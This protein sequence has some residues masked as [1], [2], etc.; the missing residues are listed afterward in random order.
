MLQLLLLLSVVCWQEHPVFR[1]DVEAVQLDVYVERDGKAV[2]DLNSGDFEVYDEGV[3]Q[4]IQLRQSE[5]EP[6]SIF[7]IFDTSESV[8]GEKLFQLKLAARSFLAGL[9]D[10]DRAALM[11]FSSCL[12]LRSGLGD[13]RSALYESLAMTEAI[14]MTSLYDGLYAGLLQVEDA[15][16]P[17]VLLFTDGRDTSSWIS[18]VEVLNV[19]QES[20]AVIY[21]VTTKP[22]PDETVKDPSIIA[23]NMRTAMIPSGKTKIE[24]EIRFLQEATRLTGGRL[25]FLSSASQLEASF[26]QILSELGTRY[27]LTYV[28]TG[29]ERDGWHE[30]EVKVKKRGVEV[31]ARRG[32]WK[33]ARPDPQ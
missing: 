15:R 13:D 27:L 12:Q 26:Q 16:R 8:R 9:R 28:P 31:R 33:R 19:A 10:E 4:D 3:R 7:L 11:T 5:A 30:L 24:P 22:A 1:V 14:G 29:V 32:Y 21:A 6:R 2:L 17:L 23:R 18:D 20:N 25:L